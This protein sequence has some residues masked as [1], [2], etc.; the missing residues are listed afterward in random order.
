MAGIKRTR[1]DDEVLKEINSKLC[2]VQ[3]VISDTMSG[4]SMIESVKKQNLNL[5][6]FR[7][8][9][10]I[11]HAVQ[12]VDNKG[13]KPLSERLTRDFICN[14]IE[15]LYGD[16]FAVYGDEWNDFSIPEDAEESY[17]YVASQLTEREQKVIEL[18]YFDDMTLEEAGKVFSVTRDRIRQILSKAVRKLRHP[19]R[20][21]ILSVGIN[22]W[23]RQQ[24]AI[25][26]QA[27]IEK[28][29]MEQAF[30]EKLDKKIEEIKNCDDLASSFLG[31]D[32]RE[33]ELS[34]RSY[35]CLKRA[36]YHTIR[37]ILKAD[38]DDLMR[39]RNLGRKS[40]GEV[41]KNTY[42]YLN[43]VG[44]SVEQVFSVR[45]ALRDMA[46]SDE[47]INFVNTVMKGG[48]PW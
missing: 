6:Q 44:V 23:N 40:M 17:R 37:N 34:V 41:L 29:T 3:Q 48:I 12:Y 10:D 24:E 19:S 2:T 11:V 39:I 15:A 4:K 26:E 28:E 43:S 9:L 25:K 33:L 35:N 16:I 27:R 30:R 32:I 7:R 13:S 22:E 1:Y 8:V 45:I 20:S 36:S 47:Y 21:N 14:P 18:Y 31:T 38:L 5:H 46:N 42:E